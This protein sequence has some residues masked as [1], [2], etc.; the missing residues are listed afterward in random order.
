[1]FDGKTESHFLKYS[2]GI[3]Y[4]SFVVLGAG[5][6]TY[7]ISVIMNVGRSLMLENIEGTLESILVSPCSRLGYF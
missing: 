6:Y 4:I 3:D 1:M 7:S 5:L 2:N